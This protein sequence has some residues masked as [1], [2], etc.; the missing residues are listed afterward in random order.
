MNNILEILP[1]LSVGKIQEESNF[2]L[3]LIVINL[4]EPLIV[5]NPYEPPEPLYY[6]YHPV[7]II[8]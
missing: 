5:I 4:Y 7:I 6:P 8:S 2:W 3:F 1:I